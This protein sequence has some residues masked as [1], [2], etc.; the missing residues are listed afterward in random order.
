MPKTKEE[1]AEYDRAYYLANREKAT[2]YRRAYNLENHEK[3]MIDQ[4]R[5]RGHYIP[6]GTEHAAY[7]RFRD[8]IHC[9]FCGWELVEGG[10][11]TTNTKVRHHDHT[12]EDGDNFI[13]V[14]CHVCNLREKCS[15]TSGEP[16][17]SYHKARGKW[18]FIISYCG[19]NHAKTTFNTFE[20][21]LAYK[22]AWM[23]TNSPNAF[24]DPA[25]EMVLP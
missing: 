19:K 1:Q 24:H 22:R 18:V 9:E 5:K 10:K 8:T 15:N 21:A 4:W 16:N 7:T 17:I 6:E 25:W 11:R 23:D 14:I 12:I 3:V 13:A 2:E 20:E